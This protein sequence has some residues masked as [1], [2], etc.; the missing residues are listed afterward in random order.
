MDYYHFT[1]H[2]SKSLLGR[3]VLVVFTLVLFDS[4]QVASTWKYRKLIRRYP[5]DACRE[6]WSWQYLNDSIHAESFA[7]V[8]RTPDNFLP[9]TANLLICKRQ[10]GTYIGLVDYEFSGLIKP[11]QIVK[12]VPLT[13][14]SVISE[15]KS[16]RPLWQNYSI[17]H[18]AFL[19]YCLFDSVFICRIVP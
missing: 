4:C 13:D 14:S 2:C 19:N 11:G 8:P 1:C 15:N 7:F 5:L 17:T 18:K 12:A 16:I 9:A 10:D 3:F 6:N